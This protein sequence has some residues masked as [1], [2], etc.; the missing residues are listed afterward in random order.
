M[1]EQHKALCIPNI[2]QIKSDDKDVTVEDT[3]HQGCLLPLLPN[4]FKAINHHTGHFSTLLR[5][6]TMAT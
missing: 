1:D 6:Q 2:F 5:I 4:C 3:C